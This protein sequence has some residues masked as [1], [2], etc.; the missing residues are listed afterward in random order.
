MSFG[1]TKF[2]TMAITNTTATTFSANTVRIIDGKISHIP[3][4]LA[5]VNPI[6]IA[7]DRDAIVIFLW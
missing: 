7:R 2:S 4:S 5:L 3:L 1:S 6:P